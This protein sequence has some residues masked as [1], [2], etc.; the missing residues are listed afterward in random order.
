MLGI[1]V[2][3]DNNWIGE[4]NRDNNTKKS[5]SYV[6]LYFT[7]GDTKD[8]EG[9]TQAE[10][11]RTVLNVLY[12]YQLISNNTKLIN[13]KLLLEVPPTHHS[14]LNGGAL[15]TGPDSNIYAGIGDQEQPFESQAQN[16]KNGT[17]PLGTGGILRFT[18]DGETVGGVGNSILGDTH[19]LDKYY[20]YGIR[21]SFGMDFDPI[22]GKLWDTE[23][24]P[25][26][27]DEINI[28]EPGFNSGWSKVQGIWQPTENMTA[29]ELVLNPNNLVDFNRK[30]MYSLP[31][32]IWKQTVGPTSVKFFNSDKLGKEYRN[33][34]FVGDISNGY[35]YHFDLVKNRTSLN[36]DDGS[37]GP[38]ADKIADTASEL[39]DVIFGKGF[40]GIT[41]IEV[42]P[43]D[44][45][46][47]VVSHQQGT[48][49]RIVPIDE[50]RN[51]FD[52][53]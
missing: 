4:K 46:L 23:N 29:G 10:D 38:L 40:G 28:V 11:D 9:G 48:I 51:D 15:L 7:K 43:Y 35:L 13:P 30:G 20:A 18:Q 50:A 6:F 5:P 14:F 49:F 25:L 24:G 36:L 53:Q 52:N 27:G 47:Y 34:L 39:K 37:S 45:Y 16:V 26:Y 12:R 42:G 19:P 17:L 44:G 33:D 2:A 21:N 41:D 8:G 1:A 22:T 3:R 31:E 32:F